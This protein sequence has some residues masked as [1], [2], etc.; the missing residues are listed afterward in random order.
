V[1]LLPLAGLAGAL[2]SRTA[3]RL[4][5]GFAVV[6]LL[7][8]GASMV[9]AMRFSRH[10]A[11]GSIDRSVQNLLD[12][13]RVA[14]W[15]DALGLMSEHPVTG[16]GPGRFAESRTTAPGDPDARWAHQEF[17]QQG[18]E[19]GVPGLLLVL[20]VFGAS[21]GWLWARAD[22]LTAV[23]AGALAALGIHASLDYVLHFPV[24]PIAAAAIL[25][26]STTSRA[27]LRSWGTT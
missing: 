21:F 6:F 9:L 20:L 24:I 3:K 4:I 10:D 8:T 19:T 14:L 13:R 23:A 27:A 16:V 5:A 26:A 25:G 7:A 12:R 17:M 18:A 11:E 2:D 1:L 15:N 22:T